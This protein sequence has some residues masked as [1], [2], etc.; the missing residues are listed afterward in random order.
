[1]G[2]WEVGSRVDVGVDEKLYTCAHFIAKM[3]TYHCLIFVH[4]VTDRETHSQDHVG[5]IE[6][7]D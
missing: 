6:H 5:I 3:L 7:K 1:M 2:C 4:N